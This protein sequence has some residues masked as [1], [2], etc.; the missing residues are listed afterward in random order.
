LRIVTGRY[1]QLKWKYTAWLTPDE[2]LESF[3]AA[4]AFVCSLTKTEKPTTGYA[5]SWW[6]DTAQAWCRQM[7]VQGVIRSLP[8]AII[9]TGDVSYSMDDFTAVWLDPYRR[10]RPVDDTAWRKLLN[11]GDLLAPTRLE[12]FCDYSIGKVN[13]L[14]DTW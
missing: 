7:G 2:E 9:A 1:P 13:V 6:L 5:A 3:R 10:S 4:F 8:P 14:A 12:K 11:G